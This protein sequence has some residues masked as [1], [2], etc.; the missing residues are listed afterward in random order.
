MSQENYLERI[1]AVVGEKGWSNDESVLAPLLVDSRNI[2]HGKCALLVQ[3]DSTEQV[4]QVLAICHEAEIPVV[5]QGGNTGRSGGA[6][7]DTSGRSILLNLSRMSRVLDSDPA[8]YTMTVEAGCILEDIQKFA[9]GIDRYFPLSLGAQ[10][11]CQIGGNL[12][13]NAGGIN[14]VRYGNTRELVLGVEVVL[15][16]GQIWNGLRR[17][18][19]DNSGYDLKQIFIGSEG[20]LGVITA[21]VLKLFPRQVD[22]ATTLCALRDV[23]AATELLALAR[24]ASG[25]ALSSFELIPDIA[26]DFALRYVSGT[27]K[28]LENNPE[29]T[30]IMEFSGSRAGGGMSD[31]LESVLETALESGVISDAVIAQSEQQRID[32]WRLRE[33]IVEAQGLG[34]VYYR[35][36]ISVPVSQ[37]PSYIRETGEALEVLC[38]GIR[39][40]PYGHVGDGNVHYNIVQPTDM[41]G[42]AFRSMKDAMHDIIFEVA[43]HKGGSVSAE[44][45]VGQ[46]KVDVCAKYKSELERD[47]MRRIK[48]DFDPKGIMNPGKLLLT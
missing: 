12:A 26:H 9:D 3:P 1:K 10:G 47:M 17:L 27:R 20:T 37:M 11:S 19:K 18:R 42:D 22:V 25:D 30:V 32:I 21:A 24:T 28:L 48:N 43:V 41:D 8:N 29:W 4:S 45:G 36:D 23:D 15:P 14:V 13:T 44:H 5:P 6:T 39:P 31:N 35:N 38:P 46:Y 2:Y 7:P 33:A 40:Y 16:D 34:G